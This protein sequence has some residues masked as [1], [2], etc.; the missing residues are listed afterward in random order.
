MFD[1][2]RPHRWQPTRLCRPWDSPGKNTGVGC[3]F[4]LQCRKVKSENEITQ[5]CR[6]L[7]DPVDCR[8]PGSSVQGIF[9]ARVLEWLPL[10]SPVE[11]LQI[12]K[13]RLFVPGKCSWIIALNITSVPFFS[14]SALRVLN[15]YVFLFL[16]ISISTTFSLLLFI[17]LC[18]LLAVLFSCFSS[19][20]FSHSVMSNSLQPHES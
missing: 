3:H 14:F 9:Q 16:A 17:S 13:V 1:S 6:T 4:L 2:V 12:C 19:V 15:M 11:P 8:P 20:Q 18:D 5:S 10:P 7:R